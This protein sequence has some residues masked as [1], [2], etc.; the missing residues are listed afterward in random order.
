MTA[1]IIIQYAYDSMRQYGLVTFHTLLPFGP[2]TNDI[3]TA[4]APETCA[5]EVA[6]AA[7]SGGRANKPFLA[8]YD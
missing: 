2:S 5:V 8:G 4:F 7:L 3:N 6:E 1:D